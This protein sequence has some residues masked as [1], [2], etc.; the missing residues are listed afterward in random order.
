[1]ERCIARAVANA[2]ARSVASRPVRRDSAGRIIE[3]VEATRTGDAEFAAQRRAEQACQPDANVASR[4]RRF[5][6]GYLLLLASDQPVDAD[7]L[8]R[9]LRVLSVTADDVPATMLAI[10]QG[11]FAGRHAAW[12][13]YYARW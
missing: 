1:V 6:G 11:V 10:A 4:T 3:P 5:E 7:D 12:S 8:A 2:R 9:R 13:G